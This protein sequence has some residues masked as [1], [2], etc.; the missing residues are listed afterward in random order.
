MQTSCKG[1]EVEGGITQLLTSYFPTHSTLYRLQHFPSFNPK[2]YSPFISSINDLAGY[3]VWNSSVVSVCKVGSRFASRLGTLEVS[4]L[5]HSGEDNGE[6]YCSKVYYQ[7]SNLPKPSSKY[8]KTLLPRPK[9]FFVTIHAP[10][11][12]YTVDL[13]GFALSVSK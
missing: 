1:E 11:K 9:S 4:L 3:Q 10:N 7:I 5:S 8:T 6:I 13:A 2:R 12:I